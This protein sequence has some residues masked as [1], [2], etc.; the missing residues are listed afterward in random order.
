VDPLLWTRGESGWNGHESCVEPP[1]GVS[2]VWDPHCPEKLIDEAGLQPPASSEVYTHGHCIWT[3]ADCDACTGVDGR[4]TLLRWLDPGAT[5]PAPTRRVTPLDHAVSIEWD[6]V[7]EI[8]VAA[9]IAGPPG[10]QVI[11]YRIYRVADWRD[12]GSLLPPRENWSLVA[13][14]G[15]DQGHGERPL[16]SVTDTTVGFVRISYRMKQ[17]PVGRYAFTDTKVLNGFDYVYVV[18]SIAESGGIRS[19]GP[20]VASFDQRVT[21]HAAARERGS[22]VWVVPNPFRASAAWDRPPIGGD[23]LTRHIDF[24]GL[25]RARAIIKIFTLAGDLVQ[26][27]DHDGTTGDGEAAWDLVSRSGQDIES[28]VY[29]FVVDSTL[30]HQVGR[31]VVI[32]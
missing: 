32:R 27:I 8:L 24:M 15:P 3:D 22:S 9:G 16:A 30:G 11:G 2:F 5:P 10:G 7:P 21:P 4:E 23:G 12:R 26:Q 28:G 6:N 18:T 13:T 17:Y 19:E 31:F 29:L 25:P 14:F 1:P 20:L